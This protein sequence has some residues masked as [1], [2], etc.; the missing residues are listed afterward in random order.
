[1]D[2]SRVRIVL[3]EVRSAENLGAVARA[4][5]NMGLEHLNL[6]HPLVEDFDLARRVAVDSEE[7]LERAHI[8]GDFRSAIG[9]ATLVVGTTSRQVDGRTSM[10]PRALAKAV[11]S[12]TARG[13]VAIVFGSERRGLSNA[14]IDL[15]QEVATIPS[16]P[17]KPSM[18]LAQAVTVIGYELYLA[19]LEPP[20]PPGKLLRA[21]AE[22]LQR[23]YDR[24]KD[25][26]LQSGFLSPQNPDLILSEL[27]RFIERCQPSPREAELWLAAFKQIERAINSRGE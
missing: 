22:A 3:H 6:V 17:S 20:P 8:T 4:M 15:C 16:S 12:E 24:M 26:L 10:S 25:V 9:S 27:K 14:E 7:L 21:D 11:A 18:N 23:L 1:M 5:K 19:S 2:L 13:S